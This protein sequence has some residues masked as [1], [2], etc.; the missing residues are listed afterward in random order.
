MFGTAFA[1]QKNSKLLSNKLSS[2]SLMNIKTNI[3]MN[4]KSSKKVAKKATYR[5]AIIDLGTNSIRLDI[6][7]ISEKNTQRIFRD[8]TMIRLGDGV[9]KTGRLS[10]SGIKRCLE[11]FL[12]YSRLL[13]NLGVTRVTAF[14]TSALRS[15][16]NAKA[17]I[18]AIRRETGVNLRIISGKAEGRLIALGI[19]ANEVIP[20]EHYALIDIGGGST[21]ISICRGHK[22]IVGYSFK[23][24]A[25]RLQQMFFKKYPVEMRRGV[26]HPELK[27]RQHVREE[28]LVLSDRIKRQPI[29]S[30]IGSSGTIR[31]ASRILKKLGCR[32]SGISRIDLSGIVAE[33]QTMALS[34]I[35]RIPGLEPKRTDIIVPGLI[36][37]EE[38]LYVLR[39]PR[40]EVTEFALREGILQQAINPQLYLRT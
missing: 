10:E 35:K 29:A 6:Y 12:I 31:T 23:L 17:L 27:M 13:K 34:D 19:M 36:L 1:H 5:Q 20:K 32:G 24:G 11:T 16:T 39:V 21:E 7:R 18:K 38:I 25:N 26:L 28:L 33:M 22:I 15:S 3:K 14:G 9:F 30:A 4:I 8:K 37:L 40:I 2:K